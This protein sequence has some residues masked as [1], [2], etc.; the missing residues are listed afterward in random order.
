MVTASWV[1]ESVA[2]VSHTRRP[3]VCS[4]FVP[5]R[6]DASGIRPIVSAA[7]GIVRDGETLRDGVA[8]LLP[9]AAHDSAASDPAMVALMIALAALRREE[10]RGSHYRSDFAGRDA[11]V[12]LSRLTLRSAIQ[13][14]VA[15]S[16]RAPMRS[17]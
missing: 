9:I 4:A 11:D 13:T 1:A 8:T 15:L 3:R 10:S 16:W 2:D 6:P 17:T 14:A 7:L 5:Q 12:R